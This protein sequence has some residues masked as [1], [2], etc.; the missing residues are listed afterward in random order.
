M[1][2]IG[3]TKLILGRAFC[4]ALEKTKKKK[5]LEKLEGKGFINREGKA[6]S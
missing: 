1:V 5:K 2:R 6:I 4:I 3:L